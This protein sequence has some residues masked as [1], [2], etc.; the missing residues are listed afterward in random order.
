MIIKHQCMRSSQQHLSPG[1]CNSPGAAVPSGKWRSFG[2]A[3]LLQLGILPVSWQPLPCH[4][5]LLGSWNASPGA[6]G[7]AS[8]RVLKPESI[9]TCCRECKDHAL[10]PANRSQGWEGESVQGRRSINVARNHPNSAHASFQMEHPL[11]WATRSPL[12]LRLKCPL[13]KVSLRRLKHPAFLLARNINWFSECS[14]GYNS[15]R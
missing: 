9:K 7:A 13:G 10:W 3:F 14:A 2:V 12:K 5:G 4:T 8:Q 11:P 15:I 1:R 6:R